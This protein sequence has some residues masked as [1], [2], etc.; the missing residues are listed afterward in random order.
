LQNTP[1]PGTYHIHDFIEEAGLNPVRMTYGFKNTGRSE[2]IM[3][4]KSGTMLL[5]GAYNF[6]DSTQEVLQNQEPYSFKSCPRPDNYTLGSRDKVALKSSCDIDA[7]KITYWKLPALWANRGCRAT[8]LLATLRLFNEM[9]EGPAPGYYTP[10][11]SPSIA[12]TSCFRSTVPRL[13][14]IHS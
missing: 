13:Y 2:T 1:L 11:L 8:L 4:I 10:N 3:C 5:P 14:S 7:T 6:T 12:I 9:K